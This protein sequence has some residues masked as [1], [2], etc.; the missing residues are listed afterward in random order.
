[1]KIIQVFSLAQFTYFVIGKGVDDGP[2][3]KLENRYV[4]QFRENVACC[5]K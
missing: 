4:S 5:L 2:D 1:M 3:F